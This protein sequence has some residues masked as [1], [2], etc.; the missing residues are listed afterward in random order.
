MLALGWQNDYFSGNSKIGLDAPV[1]ELPSAAAL[2]SWEGM[3]RNFA[4]F[5]SVTAGPRQVRENLR[6]VRGF[7][8]ERLVQSAEQIT[9]R[10]IEGHM[11]AL[12]DSGKSLKTLLNVRA[13][14]SRFCQHL[15]RQELMDSNPA[16]GVRIRRPP[17][18]VP[19]ILDPLTIKQAIR[20]ARR[21][22]IC[23]EVGLG[24]FCGLRRSEMC[25][26]RWED[27]D[28][29]GSRVL[30][31]QSKSGRFRCVP[32]CRLLGR[33]LRR[34][35]RRTF[36]T[37]WVFPARQTFPGGSRYVPRPC[38]PQSM[39]L[40]IRPLQDAFPEFRS[41]AGKRVGR[42]FHLL[43]HCFAS[44]L[45]RRGVSIYKIAEWMGHSDVKMTRRYARL[46]AAYDLDIERVNP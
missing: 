17:E 13:A 43:R 34:Q 7:L 33:I 25:R 24:V 8:Q 21:H 23:A 10:S 36:S 42:G 28:L 41:L 18:I 16:A 37:G 35:R 4:A 3:L 31:R 29:D 22:G 6:L 14:I 20:V 12:L 26:L 27:V 44:L 32:V 2:A 5:N 39:G 1:A 40:R 30:V 15:R 9:A 46:A 38:S 11:A 19:P 45:A